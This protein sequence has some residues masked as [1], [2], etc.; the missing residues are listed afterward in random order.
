MIFWHRKSAISR[1]PERVERLGCNAELRRRNGDHLG[2]NGAPHAHYG[3]RRVR[4]LAA[5]AAIILGGAALSTCGGGSSDPAP[6]TTATAPAITAQPQSQTVTVGA[7]ATFTVTATGTAPLSYQWSKGGVAISGATSA[8]YT[9]PATQLTD[10]AAS[11]TVLVSNS[12][13][14]ITS[15]AAA[16]TVTAVATAPII[17]SQPQSQSVVVGSTTTFTVIATGAGPL[18]YQW[19]KGATAIGGATA[20]SYTT[21]ATV[22]GDSG[23]SFTVVVTN[24]TGSTTST[25]AVLTTLAPAVDVTTYHNDI[26]RTGQN[27]SESTLTS[28]NVKQA[29]F[30]LLHSLP[31]NGKVDAQPLVLAGFTIGGAPHNVVY[32]ATEHDSVYAFDAD[33][34]VQLWTVSLL[35]A[36]ETTSDARGCNQVVPEIGITATPV[37]DRAA[38]KLFVVAMS[39]VSSNNYFQRLHVLNLATG[40]EMPNSPVTIAASVPATG[41]SFAT[42]GRLVFDAKQYK[43]RSALLLSQ[44]IIYT[45]WAS[46]CDIGPYTGWIIAYNETTLQQTAVYDDEPSW[47]SGGGSGEAAFWNSNSG[48]A[49]D[50]AGNLYAMTGNGG[51]DTTLTTGGF[52]IG[53]DYG[54]AILKLAPPAGGTQSVT[55]YFTMFNTVSESGM[56]ADLGSGGIMLLPDV[57]DATAHTRHLAVGAG[58]DRIIYVVDRDNLGKFKT[59]DNL[60][61]YQ[62]FLG[63]PSSSPGSCGSVAGV[64]GAPVYF[65]GVVYFA[66]AGDLIRAFPVTS[67]LLSTVPSSQTA[68]A[69]CFPGAS[70]A[71]SA[72]GTTNGILWAVENSSTQ[73]ALHAFD[74]TNL[75]TEL[76]NSKQ[77]GTRDQ[78]GPGAKFTPPTIANGKV[79]V[80]TQLNTTGPGQNYV[81]VFGLL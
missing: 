4:T 36:G 15:S 80:G 56:D 79:F 50:A 61:A 54:N 46:H 66:A 14:N 20:A 9:T 70:L 58:K 23:S 7:A 18:T 16:L 3:A 49:A 31:V 10:N 2:L 69:F 38:G 12:A 65:N 64:F 53:N 55:D 78:F 34:G 59:S 19:S 63:F 21:P 1:T 73:G 51:F 41:A 57:L 25:P 13:G 6:M 5:I 68:Q 71:V 29:T 44:G 45:S 27:L 72:N 40:A 24:A 26:A 42:G 60:N 62:A 76:Y 33:S 39:K 81:A 74:A 48:P 75:A 43:E 11:F 37:I 35:G 22:T 77:A 30:G 32:V 17:T 67:A 28:S 52:P 47:N 8:T